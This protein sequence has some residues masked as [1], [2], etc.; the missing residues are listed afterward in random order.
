VS[1]KRTIVWNLGPLLSETS[2]YSHPIGRHVAH[3][4]CWVH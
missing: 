2:T 4:T 1:L 3:R